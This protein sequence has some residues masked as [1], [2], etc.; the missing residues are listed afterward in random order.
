MSA[1]IENAVNFSQYCWEIPATEKIFTHVILWGS[2][3]C[4]EF[5]ISK[6]G[7]DATCSISYS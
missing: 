6:F 1:I 7:D 5:V 4:A 2:H 3:V